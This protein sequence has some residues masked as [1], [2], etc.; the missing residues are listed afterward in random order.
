MQENLHIK[1]TKKF[2]TITAKFESSQACLMS[3]WA[4]AIGG[5]HLNKWILL[6]D[7]KHMKY[8]FRAA[9]KSLE[10]LQRKPLYL[11][12]VLTV[13][14]LFLDEAGQESVEVMSTL[15]IIFCKARNSTTPFGGVLNIGT[16]NHTQC[17]PINAMPFYCHHY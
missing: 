9:N 14:V 1:Y 3:A 13:D 4:N 10:K 15:D 6:C 12:L 11:H 2:K 16:L 5:I 8:P 17:H 7:S